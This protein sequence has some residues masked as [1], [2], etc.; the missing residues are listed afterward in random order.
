MKQMS[1]GEFGDRRERFQS[2]IHPNPRR[3]VLRIREIR[4]RE[5]TIVMEAD[6]WTES[7]TNQ[8]ALPG[9]GR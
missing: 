3:I 2:R 6:R 8:V 1:A 5:T 9:S 4:V 7:P